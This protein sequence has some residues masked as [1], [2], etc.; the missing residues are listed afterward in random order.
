MIKVKS[1][2]S[3]NKSPGVVLAK[4]SM[5]LYWTKPGNANQPIYN[6]IKTP[7][8]ATIWS[9]IKTLDFNPT[10]RLQIHHHKIT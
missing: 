1:F 10:H 8:I 6:S 2:P 5:K 3:L 9:F 7:H 4:F